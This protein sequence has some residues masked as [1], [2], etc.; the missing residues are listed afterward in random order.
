MKKISAM[1]VLFIAICAVQPAF[2]QV[3]IGG[4]F[5]YASV[6]YSSTSTTVLCLRPM[7]L[8]EVNDKFDIGGL[9]EYTTFTSDI[10]D[11][12]KEFSIGPVARYKFPALGI[13]TPYLL[14]DLLFGIEMPEESEDDDT[15]TFG[16]DLYIGGDLALTDHLSF[17]LQF[18]LAG[19]AFVSQDSDSAFAFLADTRGTLA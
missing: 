19:F 2:S 8:Y 16:V 18:P 5:S 1:A 4:G 3:I 12:Y 9:L 6:D 17:F 10:L 11:E 14:G 7:V 15:T 13:F